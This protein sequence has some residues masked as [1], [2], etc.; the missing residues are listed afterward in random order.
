[1]LLPSTNKFHP[2]ICVVASFNSNQ[3]NNY[4]NCISLFHLTSIHNLGLGEIGFIIIFSRNI[5]NPN[6]TLPLEVNQFIMIDK[7]SRTIFIFINS[8]QSITKIQDLGRMGKGLGLHEIA[9][10]NQQSTLKKS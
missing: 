5:L 10:I 9:S 3:Y 7:T 4:N 8:H 2:I 6:N 1:M